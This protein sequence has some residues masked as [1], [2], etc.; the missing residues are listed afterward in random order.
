MTTNTIRLQQVAMRALRPH[1]PSDNTLMPLRRHRAARKPR[2]RISLRTYALPCLHCLAHTWVGQVL[3]TFLLGR[4]Q[5]YL[6]EA[7]MY[8]VVWILAGLCVGQVTKYDGALVVDVMT[9]CHE[10]V[11]PIDHHC[12]QQRIPSL[13]FFRSTRARNLRLRCSR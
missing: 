7:G 11:Q 13:R 12:R 10:D 2:L 3:V 8:D 6:V 5:T 4:V 1:Q 9:E